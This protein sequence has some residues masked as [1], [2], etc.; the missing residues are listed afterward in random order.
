MASNSSSLGQPAEQTPGNQHRFRKNNRGANQPAN[1]GGSNHNTAGI[2][3]HGRLG[4]SVHGIPHVNNHGGL[5]QSVHNTAGAT[6]HG[7]LGQS[8]HGTPHANNHGGLGQSVHN[9]AG[10]P[11]H[12]GL[13]QSTHAS[14][15]GT[16]HGG[17]SNSIHA[18]AGQVNSNTYTSPQRPQTSTVDVHHDQARAHDQP[19]SLIT[20]QENNTIVASKQPKLEKAPQIITMG[21][22]YTLGASDRDELWQTMGLKMQKYPDHES[23]TIPFPAPLNFNQL[24]MLGY[25]ESSVYLDERFVRLVYRTHYDSNDNE[26]ARDILLGPPNPSVN[27]H[28]LRFQA[29]MADAWWKVVRWMDRVL[30][31]ENINLLHFL[32]VELKQEFEQKKAR[33]L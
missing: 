16:S 18:S 8:V 17:L 20:N 30:G 11:N 24:V 9:S 5:S 32:K 2:T 33:V 1:Q 15:I 26:V 31:G 25:N 6:T 4:Q 23:W 22:F 19:A 7:G 27:L 13:H 21:S 3:T 14:T 28:D 10:A 29:A 12:G